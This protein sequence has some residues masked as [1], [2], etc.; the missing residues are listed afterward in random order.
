MDSSID[1]FLAICSN[2]ECQERNT[3]DKISIG[4]LRAQVKL[5]QA[6]K[7]DLKSTALNFAKEIV[8]LE[9]AS[10]IASTHASQQ[11]MQYQ[12]ALGTKAVMLEELEREKEHLRAQAS[13]Q[14]ATRRTWAES[15]QNFFNFVSRK[16]RETQ[17]P[18]LN[19]GRSLDRR[20]YESLISS[21]ADLAKSLTEAAAAA[22]KKR[23]DELGE[24]K[25]SLQTLQNM[26]DN[27]LTVEHLMKV[28]ENIRI[29]I[30]NSANAAF[31]NVDRRLSRLSAQEEQ[32]F[33]TSEVAAD[34]LSP[35]QLSPRKSSLAGTK[36]KAVVQDPEENDD[37]SVHKARSPH[38]NKRR[39][40][41]VLT[42]QDTEHDEAES[43]MLRL[44]S[45]DRYVG[46]KEPAPTEASTADRSQCRR[47]SP[48]KTVLDGG[49]GFQESEDDLYNDI[50]GTRA[51]F[52]SQLSSSP[53]RAESSDSFSRQRR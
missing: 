50:W 6:D 36:R 39:S 28:Q 13:T 3:L 48:P 22:E 33:S 9:D 1:R 2:V 5:L 20:E 15:I 51:S 8:A 12:Q 37:L 25:K 44:S 45:T 35:R 21:N 27:V 18:E 10:R 16:H 42:R 19:R 41:Y 32:F 38:T 49:I 34:Q 17:A 24:L 52:H 23:R 14:T 47:P 31:D 29:M 7:K 43:S 30:E 26:M 53:A 4:E 40:R 46:Q 11:V